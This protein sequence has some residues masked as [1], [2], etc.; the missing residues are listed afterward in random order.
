MRSV[1]QF[2]LAVFVVSFA[3]TANAGPGDPCAGAPWHGYGAKHIL[4]AH[5]MTAGLG[6]GL[7][8]GAMDM[9]LDMVPGTFYGH[10]L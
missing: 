2:A 6:A 10:I 3:G 7:G 1:F 4:W 5:F 9:V 8:A